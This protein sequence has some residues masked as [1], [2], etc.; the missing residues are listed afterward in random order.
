[1]VE[2][3]TANW[4]NFTICQLLNDYYMYRVSLCCSTIHMYTSV[5]YNSFL[6]GFQI[7]H[8]SFSLVHTYAHTHAH[9]HMNTRTHA[10][11]H[12]HARTHTP[13]EASS[14]FLSSAANSL[15]SGN[16]DSIVLAKKWSRVVFWS[17][18]FVELSFVR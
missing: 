8:P 1:M 10:C 7:C 9:A 5:T 2:Y 14:T 13:L 11:T 16:L 18:D 17:A 3:H 6:S 4:D 15:M 12:T